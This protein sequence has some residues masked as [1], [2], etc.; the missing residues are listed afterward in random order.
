MVPAREPFRDVSG[1]SEEEDEFTELAPSRPSQWTRVMRSPKTT[2]AL[3]TLGALAAIGAGTARPLMA[4]LFG[5]LVNLYNNKNGDEGLT[6][7]K[8]EID[9]KVLLLL[10]IFFGQWFLV[11][12][13]GILLSVAAMRFT[14]RMRALYLKA[15]VSQDIEQVSESNAATD[16][17][18]NA[19]VIEDALAEKS[20][21]IL[22]AA[23]TVVISLV[24]AFYWSWHLAL[25][26]VWVIV[27]L[28]MKDV[29][30][31][32][33]EAQLERHIQSVEADA[34]SIAEECIS[35]IRTVIACGATS[36]FTNRYAS[37][38]DKAKKI[39]FRKSPIVASQ[40]AITYFAVLS[41]YA[42]AF[43]YGTKL[44]RRG[45][46]GSGGAICM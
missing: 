1:L 16:L 20:G 35:S 24:I 21:T 34:T 26:L 43:W 28:V 4:I 6:H 19:S 10:A 9:N 32:T 18:T 12:A 45:Q 30:T 3:Q 2:L 31:G 23:S 13:Y 22:Q 44:Y 46:I 29:I 41:A 11:C 17:S 39:A 27:V 14:M 7:L 25:G 38:L 37:M 40:Y 33:I 5:N 36:K 8:H 42:L 15:V